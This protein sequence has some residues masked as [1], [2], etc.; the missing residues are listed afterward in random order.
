MRK[1]TGQE[2]VGGCDVWG[3]IAHPEVELLGGLQDH[4][5]SL[6]LFL[7]FLPQDLQLAQE[8]LDLGAAR[9]LGSH[10]ATA[11]LRVVEFE[12]WIRM[13]ISAGLT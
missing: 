4:H 11:L 12:A 1:S 2:V 5:V 10:Q 7:Q 6:M 8:L 9:V 13:N 3:L